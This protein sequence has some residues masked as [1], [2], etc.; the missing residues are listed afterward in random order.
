MA[1]NWIQTHASCLSCGGLTGAMGQQIEHRKMSVTSRLVGY[2]V[3]HLT[4]TS[5]STFGFFEYAFAHP[6]TR[7]LVP[8][9]LPSRTG[10]MSSKENRRC[11]FTES[12]LFARIPNL[13]F[14]FIVFGTSASR[15]NTLSAN[16]ANGI[17]PN[18]LWSR[19]TTTFSAPL[20]SPSIQPQTAQFISIYSPW[21]VH[22]GISLYV[23]TAQ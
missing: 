19:L 3:A 12:G 8:P 14:T 9:S 4:F 7:L 16:M 1:F 13:R 18:S 11:E 22:L 21:P 6:L 20:S 10:R 17:A 23:P 15:R 5:T 2:S